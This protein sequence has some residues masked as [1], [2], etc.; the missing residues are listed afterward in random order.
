MAVKEKFRDIEISGRRFRIGRFDAR[1][2]SYIAFRL[3][4]Q[5]LP[6]GMDSE[7][8]GGIGESLPKNRPMMSRD[9]FMELQNDCLRVCS[10]I[11]SVGGNDAPVLVLMPSGEW[12]VA[13]LEDD[14]VMVIA[15]TVHALVFNVSSFFDGNALSGIMG[16]FQGVITPAFS[17]SGA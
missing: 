13:G 11:Q 3:M 8:F 16:S 5:I 4:T 17:P 15:L 6:M 14:A 1:T 10:E 9:E 7:V 2:G 12:G